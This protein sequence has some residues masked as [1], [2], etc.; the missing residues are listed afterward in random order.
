MGPFVSHEK[1]KCCEYKLTSIRVGCKRLPV[2]N[3]LVY[4]AAA[5]ITVVK[6]FMVEVLDG[7]LRAGDVWSGS[8]SSSRFGS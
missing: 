2:T 8:G 5:K 3:A 4:K 6:S 1:M 7:K